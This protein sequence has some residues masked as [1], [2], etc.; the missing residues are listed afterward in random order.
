MIFKRRLIYLVIV[1]VAIAAAIH[2]FQSLKPP[3]QNVNVAPE[4]KTRDS[5]PQ[6]PELV[7]PSGFINTEAF[8]LQELIGKKVILVDFWTYSCINCQR[9][10]PYLNAWYEKYRDMGLEIVGVH[11]PEFKFEQKIENVR[12]AVKKFGIKYPVVLDNDYATWNAYGNHYWP[13]KYL[14][15]LTGHVVAYHAGEGAYEETEMKIQELLKARKEV[16]TSA[17]VQP[18]D[19]AKVQSPETYFGARRNEY[20]GN[21]AR[22]KAGVQN[23]AVPAKILPNR[24][25]LGGSW[26]IQEEFASNLTPNAKLAYRFNAK[27]VYLVASSDQPVQIQIRQDGKPVKSVTIQADELY[28]LIENADYGEHLLEIIVRNPGL[29]IFAFT[30][31]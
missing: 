24:F 21:G 22:G 11:T 25:Y 20:F 8:Q 30:F 28:Q 9:T 23:L 4:N 2:Y 6:A 16:T 5:G 13:A 27:N 18:V 14:I 7:N 1:L 26:D 17:N 29:R 31:G 10:L 19:F 3:R 15:D 12:S